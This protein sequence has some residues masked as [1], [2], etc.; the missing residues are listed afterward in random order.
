MITPEFYAY[1]NEWLEDVCINEDYNPNSIYQIASGVFFLV[2][3]EKA[4]MRRYAQCWL[5][6]DSLLHLPDGRSFPQYP[7]GTALSWEPE[8]TL[9]DEQ[10]G[11]PRLRAV[12]NALSDYRPERLQAIR[13]DCLKGYGDPVFG[14]ASLKL[15]KLI[16]LYVGP[17]T[18]TPHDN[19][20][21]AVNCTDGKGV[22]QS[23]LAEGYII[24]PTGRRIGA[25]CRACAQVVIDEYQ[26]KL[27]QTWTFELQDWRPVTQE[28]VRVGIEGRGLHQLSEMGTYVDPIHSS[29][30][31][32]GRLGG[33]VKSEAKTLAVRENGKK[34]GRPKKQSTVD[35]SLFD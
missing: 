25:M 35:V 3:Q 22:R 29:A 9:L 24:S 13:C 7:I 4:S 11:Y 2:F 10:E 6:L 26:T 16:E 1:L 31:V 12:L 14:H 15:L 18:Y 17:S 5:N 20:P 30:A 23:H 8:I 21:Y 32:L 19:R 28:Q 34:G 33:K 27:G